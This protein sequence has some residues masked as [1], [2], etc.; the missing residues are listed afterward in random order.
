[1]AATSLYKCAV[2]E[3]SSETLLVPSTYIIHFS[4][5]HI[6]QTVTELLRMM[7]TPSTLSCLVHPH[8]YATTT[9]HFGN[10]AERA[11]ENQVSKQM[12][13]AFFVL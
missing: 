10:I 9:R 6:S 2:C 11:G 4:N 1:M 13:T 12:A 5:S 3:H 8:A 7:T